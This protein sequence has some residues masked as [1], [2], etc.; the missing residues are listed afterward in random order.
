MTLDK[1]MEIK[2]NKKLN[3]KLIRINEERV[4][5]QCVRECVLKTVNKIENS[6]N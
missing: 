3:S 6:V 5:A 4:C 1:L 2:Q